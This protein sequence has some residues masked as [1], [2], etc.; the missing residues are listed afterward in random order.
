[1]RHSPPNGTVYSLVN[2]R[3]NET[4]RDENDKLLGSLFFVRGDIELP[5][6][7]ADGDAFKERCALFRLWQPKK[8]V[9]CYSLKKTIDTVEM[10]A[11]LFEL[12]YV[13]EPPQSKNLSRIDV[14]PFNAKQLAAASGQSLARLFL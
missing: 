6:P 11:K 10:L 2:K 12:R 3:K 1:M 13:F 5:S 14:L 4:I 9:F 7:E 8:G